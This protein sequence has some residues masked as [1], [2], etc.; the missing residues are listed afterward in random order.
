MAKRIGI[1]D[2]ND[3]SGVRPGVGGT[4]KRRIYS[5]GVPRSTS[6]EQLNILKNF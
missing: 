1:S 4:S 2:D 3:V 5:W 6:T